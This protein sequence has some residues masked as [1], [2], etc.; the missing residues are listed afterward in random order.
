MNS[1]E[2]SILVTICYFDVFDYPLTLVEIWQW[3]YVGQKAETQNLGTTKI[4]DVQNALDVSDYLKKR[5]ECQNGFYFLYGRKGLVEKRMARYNI[6]ESKYKKAIRAIKILKYVPYVK[7]LAICNNL[8]YQ[9]ARNDSDID[10]FIIIKS[11]RLF[12]ARLLVTL[13]THFLRMRRHHRL[14]KDRICLSFYVTD[15]F[16]NL[17]SLLKKPYDPHFAFWFSQFVPVYDRG[18]F[19][20]LMEENGWLK[21]YLPNSFFYYTTLRRTVSDT[22][23][24]KHFKN[25]CEYILSSFLGD[26][27]EKIVRYLQMKRIRQNKSSKLRKGGT[28][29]IAG[30][31]ILK[32]HEEDRREI[33]RFEMENRINKFA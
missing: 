27:L 10:L 5:I 2:K 26:W 8:S 33:Y 3:L 4:F 16:L 11:G 12:S 23:F 21:N 9:N 6:A 32:F 18:T 1:L 29:V 28:D 13:I 20:K 31:N 19:R 24:S 14:I 25:G 30:D 7:T 17:E 15:K 22:F